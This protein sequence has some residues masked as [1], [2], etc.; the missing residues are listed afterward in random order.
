MLIYHLNKW[1]LICDFREDYNTRERGWRIVRIGLIKIHTTP[2]QGCFLPKDNYH[3]FMI[4]FRLW[5][6]IEK[7]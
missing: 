2:D 6:P 5:I 3:G 7:L 1:Q 4:A